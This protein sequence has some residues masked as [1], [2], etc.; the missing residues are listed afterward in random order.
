VYAE[1]LKLMRWLIEEV[2]FDG[3]R[4]DFVKGYGANTITAI[5][6]YRYMRDG[7]PLVPYGVAIRSTGSTPRTS[8]IA[9]LSMRL[10]FLCVKC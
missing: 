4:Y 5:Q 2:R 9:I 8:P 7:K 10:I 1:L 3:F 6:E